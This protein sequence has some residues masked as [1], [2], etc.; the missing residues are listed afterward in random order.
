MNEAQ[1]VIDG[2]MA[3]RDVV[4]ERSTRTGILSLDLSLGGSFP[5][6]I[7]EIYGGASTGKT[8]LLYRI[9]AQAQRD[10]YQTVLCPTEYLDTPYME[11]VGADP[12]KVLLLTADCAEHA[13]V[14]GLELLQRDN[15]VLAFDSVT[16]LRPKFDDRNHWL[17][18]VS[19]FLDDVS[20]CLGRESCLVIVNQVRMHRSVD[21][22]RFF[23]DQTDSAARKITNRIST[24]LE[25]SRSAISDD[26]FT[27]GV[28]IVANTLAR[29]C[30]VQELPFT[31]GHGVNRELD[32]LRRWMLPIPG[33][34]YQL[35]GQNIHGEEAA[36]AHLREDP[37]DFEN[38]VQLSLGLMHS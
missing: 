20:G 18:L 29:P 15:V 28:N 22:S 25:L 37:E 21:P 32:Y 26:H 11:K 31:K 23:A 16:A 33:G 7:V 2:L 8:S 1:Q 6:G 30:R 24:R 36:A 5:A 19:L 17:Q 34:W 27:M 3:P 4:L 35:D 38:R 10:G 12:G 14:A 9:L 13:F